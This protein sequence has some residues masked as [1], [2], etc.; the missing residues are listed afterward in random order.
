MSPDGPIEA[1]AIKA[2]DDLGPY[3]GE[4]ENPVEVTPWQKPPTFLEQL[5]EAA[6]FGGTEFLNLI[7]ESSE[8]I[9]SRA[10]PNRRRF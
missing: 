5:K 9:S 3:W 10:Q 7:V 2:F 8:D 4:D 1:N 6:R